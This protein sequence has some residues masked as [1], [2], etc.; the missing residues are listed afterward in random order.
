MAVRIVLGKRTAASYEEK[1]PIGKPPELNKLVWTWSPYWK[2]GRAGALSAK[3]S[4]PWGIV[5][6]LPSVLLVIQ[7]IWLGIV[8]KREVCHK[9]AINK[10]KH[11]WQTPENIQ[12]Y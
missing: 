2:V 1:N 12:E 8:G 5:K 3:W 11:F 6:F 4:S 7:T 9:I 10:L